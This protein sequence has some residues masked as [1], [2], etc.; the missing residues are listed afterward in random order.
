MT[1]P[2]S[3]ARQPTMRI[4]VV[5]PARNGGE[6]TAECVRACLAQTRPAD[7]LLIVDNGSTDDTAAMASAAGARVLTEPIR[8][9]YRARN[10]GWRATTADIIAFT[11]VDCVPD[12]DWLAE[13]AEPFNDPSVAGVGGAIIQAEL[14]SASQRWMV[15][16]RFLDQAQ[17]AAHEFLPFFATANVAYR[18]SV[19]EDLDGFDEAYLSG[20]DCDMSWRIQALGS[21]MLVYRPTAR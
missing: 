16:R 8:G 18:R 12:P 2:A 17:N 21:G 11:D 19:L 7:E 15:E 3:T 5:V 9:S 4:A 20:G 14:N 1:T 10:R 6:G 13:L